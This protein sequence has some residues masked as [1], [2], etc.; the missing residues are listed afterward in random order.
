MKQNDRL[1]LTL[2]KAADF[3]AVPPATPRRSPPAF[4]ARYSDD[5]SVGRPT[6]SAGEMVVFWRIMSN[7]IA[8]QGGRTQWPPYPFLVLAV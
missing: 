3:Q 7:S 5:I 6:T 8:M 4:R 2:A 1:S